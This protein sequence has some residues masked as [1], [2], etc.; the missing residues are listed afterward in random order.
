MRH[1]RLLLHTLILGCILGKKSLAISLA[2]GDLAGRDSNARR[3]LLP[4]G[5]A[6]V[7]GLLEYDPAFDVAAELQALTALYEATGGSQWTYGSYFSGSLSVPASGSSGN[8]SA[9]DFR[10]QRFQQRNWLDM[11]VSYCQW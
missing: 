7:E 8:A 1:C 9:T 10:T 4:S 6:S 3:I 2:D 11:S 5:N